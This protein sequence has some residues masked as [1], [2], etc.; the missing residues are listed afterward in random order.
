MFEPHKTLILNKICHYTDGFSINIW[1]L[2]V[3]RLILKI[4]R[5]P[6]SSLLSNK[7]NELVTSH[8]RLNKQICYD[9]WDPATPKLGNTGLVQWSEWKN[10]FVHFYTTV[11]RNV[12]LCIVGTLKL[13]TPK[14]FP[15]RKR[16]K[17]TNSAMKSIERTIILC[18]LYIL[19][20]NTSECYK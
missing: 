18:K 5:V 19:K 10:T 20:V 16:K 13:A 3:N 6:G 14:R 4:D 12:F 9:L 11:K 8:L 7:N 1:D 17:K 15:H 2:S